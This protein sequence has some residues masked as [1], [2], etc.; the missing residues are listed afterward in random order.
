M[1]DVNVASNGTRYAEE[2]LRSPI[3]SVVSEF[4]FENGAN[5]GRRSGSVGWTSDGSRNAKIL[6]TGSTGRLHRYSYELIYLNRLL[7]R[8]GATDGLIA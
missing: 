5:G 6:I 3:L 1:R 8:F 4:Q 2:S 7:L